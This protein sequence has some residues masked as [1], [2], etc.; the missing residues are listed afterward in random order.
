MCLRKKKEEEKAP[1]CLVKSRRFEGRVAYRDD[2]CPIEACNYLPVMTLLSPAPSE[3]L[4]R[5]RPRGVL[6]PRQQRE[7]W[8]TPAIFPP[9]RELCP[10]ARRG[11]RG[12]SRSPSCGRDPATFVTRL[13][14]IIRRNARDC[15]YRCGDLCRT[16]DTRM[17][18]RKGKKREYWREK[19]GPP[20]SNT[21][22]SQ[23]GGEERSKEGCG[24]SLCL[25][26]T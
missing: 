9:C 22:K 11:T 8:D 5:M 7:G 13:P 25:R 16:S 6:P 17:R 26:D 10:G 18:G 20:V 23:E 12:G 4:R 15:I 19:G 1:L 14:F 21:A 24:E 2:L 3:R